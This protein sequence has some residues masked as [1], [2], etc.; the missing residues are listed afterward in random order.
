MSHNFAIVTGLSFAIAGF[1]VD[2]TVEHVMVRYREAG[3]PEA[4]D[5]GA[6]EGL[7]PRKADRFVCIGAI[8]FHV[9]AAIPAALVT[10][11]GRP[12]VRRQHW[13]HR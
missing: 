3:V 7:R 6:P 1:L 8:F 2:R 11:V 4:S 9:G 12:R 13:E 10:R 5:K